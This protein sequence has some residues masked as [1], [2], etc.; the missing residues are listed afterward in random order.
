MMS[1]LV[2]K[3]KKKE[4]RIYGWTQ[5]TFKRNE[6][7][8]SVFEDYLEDNTELTLK[9]P[10]RIQEKNTFIKEEEMLW[11]KGLKKGDKVD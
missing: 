11:R 10:F 4:F 8:F 1:W 2:N 3:L 9:S 6:N 7:N 5:L